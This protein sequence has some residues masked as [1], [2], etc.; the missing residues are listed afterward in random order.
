MQ[1]T[2]YYVYSN[3]ILFKCEKVYKNLEVLEV[4]IHFQMYIL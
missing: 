2:A 1:Y 3:K 4:S